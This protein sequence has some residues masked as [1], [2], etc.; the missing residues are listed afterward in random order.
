MIVTIMYR[1]SY[2]GGDGWRYYPMNIKI[3]DNC[4]VCGGKRGEPSQRTYCED[5]EWYTVDN[6]INSCGHLDKY[7]DCYHEAKRLA[8]NAG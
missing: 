1:N 5:G 4:P 6:W 7:V 2:D 8:G 3:G